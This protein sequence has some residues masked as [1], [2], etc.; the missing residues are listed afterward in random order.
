[1]FDSFWGIHFEAVA[2]L[3]QGKVNLTV[4]SHVRACGFVCAHSM[5]HQD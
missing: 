5:K 2:S 3:L 4:L 1:M